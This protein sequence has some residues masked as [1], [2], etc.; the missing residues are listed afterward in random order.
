VNTIQS[1]LRNYIKAEPKIAYVLL[2]PAVGFG[3]LLLLFQTY[4]LIT[5]KSFADLDFNIGKLWQTE[6]VTPKSSANS[7]LFIKE[8]ILAIAE[9]K[10]VSATLESLRKLVITDLT[11]K[12]TNVQVSQPV[13]Q[14]SRSAF[15]QEFFDLSLIDK[16]DISTLAQNKQL[17][18]YYSKVES[19]YLINPFM[20]PKQGKWYIGFSFAPTLSYRSFGYDPSLVSGVSVD[21]NYRYTF[22]LT[23]G[24]RNRTDK[25]ITAYTIGIDFGRHI[26]KQFSLFSGIHY[27]RYG[28]QI[29]VKTADTENPN[30]LK[31]NFMG[32][33]PQYERFDNS[34]S[35]NNIPYQN[36]YTYFEVP[37]GISATVAQL[38]KTKIT[39]DVAVNLQKM[40]HVNALVYD[41]NTDYYYW[42]NRKEK[43]FNKYGIGSMVGVTL[44]QYVGER[45]EFFINPQF[46]Y[47]LKSTFQK[48][49]PVTQ[50][51]YSTGLRIGMKQQL[52]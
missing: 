47:S 39:A 12:K 34:N 5:G 6:D 16:V 24:A 50:N 20:V 14:S 23:E 27:A 31:S 40:D 17:Q 4:S 36:T 32:K 15:V 1:K 46:K 41:F 9:A 48:P 8:R 35:Q 29:L 30:Y 10:E 26:N 19:E 44:S 28:E 43:I 11:P 3:L 25:P 7:P 52:F 21:G 49:Y 33:S 45:L 38:S 37:I 13:E 18:K 22:G 42:I 2:L 51:Q